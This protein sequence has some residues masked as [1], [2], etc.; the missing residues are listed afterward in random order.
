MT[1]KIEVK[2]NYNVQS[3]RYFLMVSKI[4]LTIL[5]IC[6][7][8]KNITR[9]ILVCSRLIILLAVFLLWFIIKY[10]PIK[11]RNR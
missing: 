7:L 10:F 4:G 1:D 3:F 8:L 11:S 5:L 9:P 2:V 6:L